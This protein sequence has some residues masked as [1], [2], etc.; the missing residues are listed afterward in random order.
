MLRDNSTKMESF[1]LSPHYQ[2][3]NTELN[4]RSGIFKQSIW[5][6]LGSP[7]EVTDLTDPCH[8][9]KEGGLA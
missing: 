9:S 5:N 3:L 4:P 8:S 6:Y 1:V 7:G 2:R